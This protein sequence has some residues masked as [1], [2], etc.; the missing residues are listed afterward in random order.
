VSLAS[1]GATVTSVRERVR[2]LIGS[3]WE[4]AAATGTLPDLETGQRPDI[5]VER[6]ANPEHGDLATNL[7]MR[8]ARPM[9]LAPQA[10]AGALAESLQAMAQGS[11][12]AEVDV[13]GPGFLNLRLSPTWL[14]GVLDEAAAA[15][16]SFGR[17]STEHPRHINVE[18]VSANPT[19]PLT[20]GNARGAFVGDLLCR[21][22]EGG[23]HHVTREYYFNDSGRQVRV[24]G[25]S[26]AARRLG[27]ELPEES[28]RGSYVDELAAELPDELWVT[29]TSPGADR[30]AL[31]VARVLEI[32]VAAATG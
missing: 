27:E 1:P 25:A 2:A 23:G 4:H 14:E 19:G 28:Y 15:G 6:P 7:A 9:R 12:L 11:A 30:D 32:S 31:H 20:V 5:E 21:V 26:V 17:V 22:L 13:A 16:E 18:F 29:A 10:I 24:L 3:A 8:L